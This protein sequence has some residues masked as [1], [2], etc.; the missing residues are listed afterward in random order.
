MIDGRSLLDKRKSSASSSSLYMYGGLQ[1]KTCLLAPDT[2]FGP[3]DVDGEL[4]RQDVREGQDGVNLYLNLGLIDFE[5]CEPLPDAWLTIWVCSSSSLSF[6]ITLVPAA[7]SFEACNATGTY[8]GY[9]GINPDTVSVL[10][11]WSTR[12]D[13]TTHD[14]TFL[15]GISK[16]NEAGI[17][18][19]LTIFPGYYDNRTTHIHAT[20]QHNVTGDDTS[21]SVTAIQH[22][23]QLFFPEELINSVYKLAP[24]HALLSTL[25]RTLNS[26]DSV[27]KSAMTDG[28]SA[29]ISTELL[30]ETLADGLIGY[31]TIVVN[32]S[33]AA[34]ATTGTQ[35]NVQGYPPTVSLTSGAQAVAN[36]NDLAQ[37]YR[38][39]GMKKV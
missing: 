19:F 17:A 16:T 14:E 26:E 2:I 20:V 5:T 35:V 9:T 32:K 25:N 4:H 38:A 23:G 8:S 39:N 10:D 33:A 31:I 22:I 36:T 30:G 37:E 21:Y 29:M 13:G 1:N 12:E 34:I 15:R 28:Y 7:N 11:G 18:E 24:Y 27:Y 6:R 3:Y